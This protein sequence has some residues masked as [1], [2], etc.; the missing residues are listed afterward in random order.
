[1]PGVARAGLQTPLASIVPSLHLSLW[2]TA[3]FI[4]PQNGPNGATAM[5]RAIRQTPHLPSNGSSER[6]P[7]K[8]PTHCCAA[9]QQHWSL[10]R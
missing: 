9:A 2:L 8:N 10:V 4:Q 6:T 5:A 7:K 3:P 1:M